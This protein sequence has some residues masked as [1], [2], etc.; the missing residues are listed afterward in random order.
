MGG[1]LWRMPDP[2]ET[3]ALNYVD[4]EDYDMDLNM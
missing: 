2:D 1:S 3:Y 4:G